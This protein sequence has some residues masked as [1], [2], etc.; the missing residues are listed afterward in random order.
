MQR[1]FDKMEKILIRSIVLG[2]VV[3]VVVQ[4]L[5]TKEPWRIYLSW[6]EKMEGQSI[7]LPASSQKSDSLT[8]A[9]K[10]KSKLNSPQ[11]QLT[12]SLE[13]FSSLPEASILVNGKKKADFTNKEVNIE[14]KAGDVL[15]IDSSL[16]NFPVDYQISKISNNL[17]YPDQ[18]TVYTANQSIVMVGKVIV[19]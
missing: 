6:G 10:V 2:L 18:G 12:L 7:G 17:A 3:L 13:K 8:A 1:F 14:V 9:N 4:G 16:Y 5:M 11:S 15:E 19:K